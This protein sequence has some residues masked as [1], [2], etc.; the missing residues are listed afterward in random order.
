MSAMQCQIVVVLSVW[1]VVAAISIGVYRELR[2]D[3]DWILLILLII[4]PFI[5][6]IVA[7][8][9]FF[10]LFTLPSRWAVRWIRA[11]RAKLPKAE[12][13]E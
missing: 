4:W 3:D 7:V 13:I 12:V 10:W 1:L 2:T 9:G 6:A 5:V 11:R 8:V